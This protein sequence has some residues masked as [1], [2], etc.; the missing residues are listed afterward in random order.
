[1]SAIARRY[2]RAVV[3]AAEEKGG[4]NAVEA[5][6]DALKGLGDAFHDSE[7]LRELLLNPVFKSERAAILSEVAKKLGLSDQARALV[8]L[9]SERDRISIL[10]E[11]VLEVEAIA[12][13]HA[14][15]L[16]A[17]VSS[18]MEL[19][20]SQI[21][22]IAAALEQRLGQPVV[23]S[24]EIDSELLGG[25]VCR[26]GDLTLDNSLRRQLEVLREQLERQST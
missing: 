1:M 20:D 18:A 16:R 23:V 21:K 3:L 2:A 4:A 26:V 10:D 14:G 19:T 25:L 11:V 24:V 13:E 22:R 9:L 5:L 8:Q 6:C 15:R 7:E 17:H 12:D